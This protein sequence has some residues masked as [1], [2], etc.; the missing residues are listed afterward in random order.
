MDN[1]RPQSASAEVDPG[2]GASIEI[3]GL[4]LALTA[5]AMRALLDPTSRGQAEVTVDLS[6]LS[7]RLPAAAVGAV[8]QQ[9]APNAEVELAPAALIARLPNQPAVR[10]VLP[11]AG[12]RIRV[13][14]AGLSFGGDDP[15][16]G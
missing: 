6:A 13:D 4:G 8:A 3:R 5:A 11:P 7:V 9:L 14:A 12:T 15:P 2:G 10:V 16:P 1:P